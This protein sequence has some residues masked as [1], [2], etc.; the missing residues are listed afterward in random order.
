MVSLTPTP[1]GT[2]GGWHVPPTFTKGWAWRHRE[3]NSKRKKTDQT[4]S[5]HHGNAHKNDSLYV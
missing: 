4:I 5:T 2:E 3:L 1:Q